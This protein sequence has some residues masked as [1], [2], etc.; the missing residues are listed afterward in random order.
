MLQKG[1]KAH[2]AAVVGVDDDTRV[3]HH[4][5]ALAG[6]I[7][8]SEALPWPVPVDAKSQK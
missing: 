6:L 1:L 3:Q 2:E 7:A 8:S 5:S 4:F